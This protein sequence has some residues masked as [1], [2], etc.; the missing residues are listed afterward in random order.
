MGQF[1]YVEGRRAP[2]TLLIVQNAMKEESISSSQKHVALLFLLC[3]LPY[4]Q[5]PVRAGT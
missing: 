1:V 2:E 5:P 3:C 4:C